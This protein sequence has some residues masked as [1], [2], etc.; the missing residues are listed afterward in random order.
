MKLH[1][2]SQFEKWKNSWNVWAVCKRL[3]DG[4]K[5]LIKAPVSHYWIYHWMKI[6]F[7]IWNWSGKVQLFLLL[8]SQTNVNF[9]NFS[10]KYIKIKASYKGFDYC[11][12]RTN[13]IFLWYLID[14]WT[15]IEMVEKIKH[16]HHFF[17]HFSDW[18]EKTLKMKISLSISSWKCFFYIEVAALLMCPRTWFQALF[19]A[20]LKICGL[21][22]TNLTNGSNA[23]TKLSWRI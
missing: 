2:L 10:F 13:Y 16:L 12:W 14:L 23:S 11:R 8:F 4:V 17:G 5:Y 19:R 6:Y 18:R 20:R 15:S 7:K 1:A 3:F 22:L 21:T 9:F